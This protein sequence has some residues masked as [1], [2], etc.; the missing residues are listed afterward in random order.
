MAWVAI[1]SRRIGTFGIDVRETR[2]EMHGWRRFP[3]SQDEGATQASWAVEE[4][5]V[6]VRA[7]HAPPIRGNRRSKVRRQ[8]IEPWR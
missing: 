3:W 2:S 6:G 7:C 8:P 5:T 4:E 1:D